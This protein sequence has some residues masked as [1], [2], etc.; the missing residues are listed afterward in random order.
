MENI[1][2]QWK[3]WAYLYEDGKLCH[4]GS[5]RYVEIHLIRRPIVPVVVE[6]DENGGHYGWME[7]GEDTPCM[8]W[9]TEVQFKMCFTYGVKAAVEAGHGRPVRL[10]IVQDEDGDRM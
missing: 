6:E 9:P 1:K 10:K 5:K 7:T 3:M 2:K 8:I 4:V